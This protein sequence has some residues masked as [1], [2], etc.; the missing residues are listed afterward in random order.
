MCAAGHLLYYGP[1]KEVMGFFQGMGFDLPA[2]RGVPDFLQEVTGRK[3]Q[4]V[5]APEL[6]WHLL[7]SKSHMQCG[8]CAFVGEQGFAG[9]RA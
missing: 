2:R 7:A 6:T 1:C 4:Q 3:D 9:F 5:S 8:L